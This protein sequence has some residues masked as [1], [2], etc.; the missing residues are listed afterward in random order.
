MTVPADT[1]PLGPAFDENGPFGR[2]STGLELENS[3]GE[4]QTYGGEDTFSCTISDTCKMYTELGMTHFARIAHT[5][6]MM[7]GG[8]DEEGESFD[9]KNA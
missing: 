8:T 4:K 1:R 7:Q 3:V 6:D 9:E 2:A 5:A